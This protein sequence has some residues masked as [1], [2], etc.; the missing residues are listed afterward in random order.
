MGRVNKWNGAKTLTKRSMMNTRRLQDGKRRREKIL[1]ARAEDS[2]IMGNIW[3][4]EEHS[5]K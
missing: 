5:K 1:R 3:K 4:L 2:V